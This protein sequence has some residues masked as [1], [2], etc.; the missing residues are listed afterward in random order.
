[1]FVNLT[2]INRTLNK[3]PVLEMFVNLTSINRTLNKVP[4]LEMFVNLS[5]INSTQEL[6][7]RKVCYRLVSL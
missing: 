5:S 3:V 6:V 2:S 1:M 7:L 4:V